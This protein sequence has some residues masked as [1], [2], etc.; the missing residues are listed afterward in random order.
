MTTPDPFP[1][2]DFDSWAETYDQ[3]LHDGND[4]PFA[5]YDKVLQT[6]VSLAEPKPGQ[7]ILDLGTGTANLALLFA[8]HGCA[9]TCTDFSPAMLDIA[10]VKLPQATFVPQDLRSDWPAELGRRF[11]CIVSAYVFH[12]FELEQKIR[13]CLDIL[14]RRLAP[15][16]HLII[17]DLSFPS[18]AAKESFKQHIPDWEEELYWFADE[19]IAGLQEAGIRVD[20]RQISPCAGVYHM[21]GSSSF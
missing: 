14:H 8:Q 4:F 9:L 17:G 21:R 1:P 12:H 19:A 18:F 10:R 16:G 2:E 13:I 20:Y 15:G 11:D 5:G 3:S 6:I 7:A